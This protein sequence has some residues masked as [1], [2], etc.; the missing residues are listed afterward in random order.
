MICVAAN[1]CAVGVFFAFQDTN[2]TADKLAYLLGFAA[3]GGLAAAV[4]WI[5]YLACELA[6]N[7]ALSLI[8]ECKWALA[9][10]AP[11]GPWDRVAEP[12]PKKTASAQRLWRPVPRAAWLVAA[13]LL[14]G[15]AAASAIEFRPGDGAVGGDF[16]LCRWAF[17]QNCVIDG[18]TI[19]YG[20]V[21]IRLADI[22]TPE[23][24]S[25]KCASEAVLGHRAKDRLLELINAG[26]IE[27]VQ[28]GEPDVDKY[29]RRLRVIKRDGRSIAETLVA[30]DLARPWDGAR[31]SWCG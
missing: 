10:P 26:P 21:K 8:S 4:T 2:A 23:I 31:R 14:G 1:W 30:E 25:P 6:A 27:V 29:G 24:S 12:Q 20:G 28:T 16:A 17:Q 7:A 22:D 9:K 19:R 15:A 11:W 18:D 13:G 5:G 3:L